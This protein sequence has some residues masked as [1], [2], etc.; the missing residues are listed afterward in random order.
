MN[1][2]ET[3]AK[4][5]STKYPTAAALANNENIKSGT[6]SEGD[7][8]AMFRRGHVVLDILAALEQAAAFHAA[9]FERSIA[10]D[11]VAGD[12]FL[13]TAKNARR[14]LDSHF[15]PVESGVLERYFWHVMF[16]AGFSTEEVEKA[17]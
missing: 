3:V 2:T 5:S 6:R 17:L 11:Y 12:N 10:Y 15:G 9:E 7:V 14:L 4:F 13:A 1:T 8:L 16:Y